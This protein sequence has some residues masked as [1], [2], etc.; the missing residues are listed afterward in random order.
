MRERVRLFFH[1]SSRLQPRVPSVFF[2]YFDSKLTPEGNNK[3]SS[4]ST[5][6][7][8]LLD[9]LSTLGSAVILH[10]PQSSNTDCTRSLRRRLYFSLSS[11]TY[12]VWDVRASGDRLKTE[13]VAGSNAIAEF[14]STVWIESTDSSEL[15][16]S[17]QSDEES[18]ETTFTSEKELNAV[19]SIFFVV[20]CSNNVVSSRT[21]LFSCLVLFVFLYTLSMSAAKKVFIG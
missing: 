15:L 16:A 17:K 6:R 4:R 2:F 20:T 1:T 3:E 21:V 5:S 7:S 9:L 19:T 14:E 18:I 8:R 11:L 13:S 12:R 10:F